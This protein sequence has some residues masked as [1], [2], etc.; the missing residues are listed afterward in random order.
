MIGTMRLLLWDC[1]DRSYSFYIEVS[2]NQQQWRMV[3]DRTKVTCRYSIVCTLN[4]QHK[5]MSTRSQVQTHQEQVLNQ[6]IDLERQLGLSRT[7]AT[8]CSSATEF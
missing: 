2:N 4:V 5:G 7:Q 1:D 6:A 8:E 3:A